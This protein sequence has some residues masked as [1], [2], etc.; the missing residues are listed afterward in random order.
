MNNLPYVFKEKIKVDAEL[1]SIKDRK[2]VFVSEYKNKKDE[3]FRIKIGCET[4]IQKQR[5][6]T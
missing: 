4:F 6:G 5:G 2:V 1:K 3:Q